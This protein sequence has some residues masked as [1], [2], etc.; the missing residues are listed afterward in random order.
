[1]PRPDV[2]AAIEGHPTNTGWRAYVDKAS[3]RGP[4]FAFALTDSGILPVPGKPIELAENTF[5]AGISD[6]DGKPPS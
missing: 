4:I 5:I 1:K 6:W 2:A 3:I